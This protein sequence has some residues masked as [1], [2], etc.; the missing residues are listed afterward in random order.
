MW[1]TC[2]EDLLQDSFLRFGDSLVG[3]FAA[4][5]TKVDAY[6]NGNSR[7]VFA[8]ALYC[9]TIKYKNELYHSLLYTSTY[10]YPHF[11]YVDGQLINGMQHQTNRFTNERGIILIIQIQ[12]KPSQR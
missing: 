9:Q 5:G 1:W 10:P 2:P 6:G 4:V 8:E 11:C 12:A 7:L 3:I